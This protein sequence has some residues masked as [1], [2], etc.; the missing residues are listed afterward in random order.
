MIPNDIRNRWYW[1]PTYAGDIIAFTLKPTDIETT[2]ED[3]MIESHKKA[4][5]RILRIPSFEGLFVK[6]WSETHKI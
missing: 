5:K 4:Y 2:S 1:Y 6:Y 3:G